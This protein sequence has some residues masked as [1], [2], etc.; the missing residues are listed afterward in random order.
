MR[1]LTIRQQPGSNCREDVRDP[2]RSGTFGGAW[3]RILRPSSPQC[4]ALPSD[5]TALVPGETAAGFVGAMIAAATLD[6]M[7]VRLPPAS[8]DVWALVWHSRL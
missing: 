5:L 1:S 3:G 8:F 7:P 6:G 2:H 4:H